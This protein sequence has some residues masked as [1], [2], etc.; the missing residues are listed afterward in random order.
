MQLILTVALYL[1]LF[2]LLLLLLLFFLL[3]LLLL[4]HL[5]S[6]S[7]SSSSSSCRL[8]QLKTDVHAQL[9][10][11]VAHQLLFSP[12]TPHSI[13]PHTHLPPDKF[14]LLMEKCGV[15]KGDGMLYLLP[16]SDV[17]NNEGSPDDSCLAQLSELGRGGRGCT[18]DHMIYMLTCTLCVYICWL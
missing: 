11:A 2:F 13:S 3:L 6:S 7:F 9:G 14:A 15:K 18:W 4:F 1:F 17:Q 10:V 12:H 5:P 8:D 16:I